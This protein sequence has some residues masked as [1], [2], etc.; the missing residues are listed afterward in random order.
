VLQQ[1][2]LPPQL[3]EVP[4]VHAAAYYHPASLDEV[5]GDFY[6]LFRLPDGRWGF[7]LGDVCGKGAEAAALTSLTRYTLRSAAVRDPDP[8]Q[9]LATLNSVLVQE[10]DPRNP[11]FCTVVAGLLSPPAH[12]SGG[13]GVT[14]AGGGHPP[15]LVLR[16]AGGADFVDLGGQLVGVFAAP[17][18]ATA[19]VDLAP[20]DTLLL[21]TDGLTEARVDGARNRYGED[22]LLAFG[23]GRAPGPAHDV[24][25]AVTA[26]LAGFG[27]GL[28]DDTA[29]LALGPRSVLSRSS[30]ERVPGRPPS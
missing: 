27:E 30:A 8:Q 1:T 10:H 5:G 9:V 3:P 22:A 20:G 17:T 29:L 2:L 14:L 16:G 25:R 6:D 23:R 11:K 12:G 28:D 4:G 7:F 21:Y 19:A 24:V 13:C 26:V 15:P 18:F